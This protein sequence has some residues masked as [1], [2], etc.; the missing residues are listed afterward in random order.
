MANRLA[1]VVITL[2]GSRVEVGLDKI[3]QKT[4]QL[5]SEMHKLANEGKQNT[6]EYK[7][8]VK[9]INKLHKAETDIADVTKRI[10]Q[11]MKNLG[12][13]ATTDLRRAYREGIQ[14]R[15]GFKGTDKELKQLNRDLAAMKAQIDKNT[16]STSS[17][18]KAQLGFAGAL[19]TT[20]KNLVAYAGVFAMFNRVKEFAFDVF[21]KNNELSDQLANI[22]KVSQLSMKEV[23][24][25]SRNIAK[26]DTRNSLSQLNELAYL[27]SKLG[28]AKYGVSGLTQFTEA[29]AQLNMALGEDMG[30]QAL[31]A[32]AKMTEVMGDMEKLGVEKALLS[33]GSAI[34]Q[35]AA[36]S[37]ASG[38]QIMEFSK[39]LLGVGKTAHLTSAEILGL[40]SA[41]D[42]MAL[43]PEVAST[44]F[45]KFISTLQSKYGQIG[46]AVGIPPET[47]KSLLETGKTM[48]AI[49]MVL[50]RM[51]SMGGLNALMPIMGDLGSEGARLTNVFAS[52]AENVDMLKEHLETSR[53]AFEEAIAVT[54][55]FNIQNSTSQAL[56]ERASNLWNKAFVNTDNVDIIH[57]FAEAWY[58]VSQRI[59]TNQGFL[60]QV[61]ILVWS[62]TEALRVLIGALPALGTAMLMGGLAKAWPAIVAGWTSAFHFF[63]AAVTRATN[64]VA[65]NNVILLENAEARVNAAMSNYVYLK[66][67]EA[68]AL[69]S[70]NLATTEIEQAYWSSALAGIREELAIATSKL[71]TATG[72]AAAVS[73]TNVETLTEQ[74]VAET[75]ATA[76]A[77]GLTIA[78]G[79]LAI[80]DEAAAAASN[81]HAVALGIKTGATERATA[82]AKGLRTAWIMFIGIALVELF[83]E[84]KAK[85]DELSSE[86]ERAREVTEKMADAIATA[87][88]EYETARKRLESLYN[89]IRR[90]WE[91]EEERRRLIDQM[92]S[93]YGDY[94]ENLLNEKSSMEDVTSAYQKATNALREYY[95]Y[96]QK[97]ALKGELVDDIQRGGMSAFVKLQ[98][99][100]KAFA[101]NNPQS[102]GNTLMDY[103][104]LTSPSLMAGLEKYVGEAMKANKNTNSDIITRDIWKSFTGKSEPGNWYADMSKMPLIGGFFPKDTFASQDQL[105]YKLLNQFVTSAMTAKNNEVLIEYNFPGEY[106][107]YN[108][109][110]PYT[111]NSGTG[112]SGGG[113]GGSKVDAKAKA[114]QTKIM[115]QAKKDAT[116]LIDN[117]EAYYNLQTA[118][119]DQSVVDGQRT[120]DEAKALKTELEK[121]RDT[122]LYQARL[123]I[124]GQE[125]T[126]DDLRKNQMGADIDMFDFSELSQKILG[127]ILAVNLDEAYKKLAKFDGSDAVYGLT[128]TAFLNEIKNKGTEYEKKRAEIEAKQVEAI[129]NILESYDLIE[130]LYGDTAEDFIKLGFNIADLTD[131][132]SASRMQA[133]KK[134]LYNPNGANGEG[135]DKNGKPVAR[136][137]DL[138]G[139]GEDKVNPEI[140]GK[141][142]VR[143]NAF[144][145]ML[146]QFIESGIKPYIVDI[147]D[148]AELARWF[149][150]FIS[151]GNYNEYGY[152]ILTQWAGQNPQIKEL[153]S[154]LA[155]MTKNNFE[156]GDFDAE[157]LKTTLD[158]IRSEIQT[159]WSALI[160]YEDNYFDTQKKIYDNAKKRFEERWERSGEGQAFS[161]A[162]KELDLM[163]RRKELSGAEKGTNFAQQAGFTTLSTDPEIAASM[164]RMEQARRELE[165]VKQ[166]SED[167]RL[168]REKEQE[169]TEAQMK[170][171]EEV[172]SKINERIT[173][174]QEWTS[175][176]EQFGESVGEAMG[177]ALRDGESMSEGIK[178]ALR[179]M[180]EAYGKSTIKIVTELMMQRLRKKMIYRAM[181]ADAKKEQ[182]EE[183]NIEQEGGE[184]RLEARS[185][186][187]TGIAAITQ[188]AS[189]EILATKKQSD[190]AE[191]QEEGA[192]AKGKVG[193]GIAEGA[194]DII[195]KLGWWGIPLIAVITAL[196][197]GLLS[198]ALNAL[199]G[200]SNSSESTTN[201]STK[202][203][204][205]LVSSMLTYDSGNV[206]S[207]LGTD[208]RFYRATSV[209]TLPDGV[210]IV[211]QP[212]A[213]TVNGQQ[214]L[215]GEQGP[216]IV[217]GRR[218]SRNIMMNEPAL[219]HH[220]LQLDRNRTVAGS[221]QVFDSGNL[222]TV[223][224]ANA[225]TGNGPLL[226]SDTLAALR[227]LPVVMAALNEQLKK[228][229]HINMYGRDGIYEKS[230]QAER[231]MKQY[232]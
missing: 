145:Q 194:A 71:A 44:A 1:K 12:N 204:T 47:L 89:Q 74:V 59:T 183:T 54:N 227:A 119:L 16:D 78:D 38:S 42:A 43:M 50:E 62:I 114:A 232:E 115:E 5:I 116:A 229:V 106:T 28:L 29:A 61:R 156:D 161:D 201:N 159:F 182:K 100:N 21:E 154:K 66:S 185:V 179:S 200:S 186:V 102:T 118:A 198:M 34:Y 215:V 101:N 33:T 190:Q 189:N 135:V 203:N 40:G 73:G 92:N 2:D 57:E 146:D 117:I 23:G 67:L 58:E 99:Q 165:L 51:R 212:I 199:F 45:N 162:D 95:F 155:S 18:S 230:R 192:K 136:E 53:T 91:I 207:V 88:Q 19:K 213:T 176:I 220:L 153:Y 126:F 225:P 120:G 20:L 82:A 49:V 98:A 169:L 147:K 80:A 124:T 27:G 110:K 133:Q 129:N 107:P 96:K 17:L 65:G 131:A 14:L 130:K 93:Q 31:P 9:A 150:D 127:E 211:S 7:E 15:E 187:E 6:K 222:T 105:D 128:A 210:S 214:A 148:D 209:P 172:M 197:S 202:T 205:K 221:R 90:N 13:V 94:L 55:E 152:G 84:L 77:E 30:E 143:V 60:L 3:R 219:L 35:L 178:N 69:E 22:R 37:T 171:E 81:E 206:Q 4:A 122:M 138:G 160:G 83:M 144:R 64:I 168:I 125:N 231:F 79:D 158:P 157:E 26:I 75:T 170:L 217:I 72:T 76:A 108:H 226:D 8:T 174:L 167:K 52:M 181:N 48:D 41:A 113:G 195:G 132:A 139:E 123:A 173:K 191:M 188:K 112:R 68:T 103:S 46:K 223:A 109:T 142:Q 134:G 216:E 218:T 151:N 63:S 193:A 32:L 228:P 180:V 10:N 70:M 39:R 56:M 149:M 25:L 97:E 111:D 36:T 87:N 140:E 104:I 137:I 11:Y 141:A 164:L 175:P 177:T 86:E 85:L 24:D 121:K 166:V 184:S 224:S 196:L 208:G 163:Q